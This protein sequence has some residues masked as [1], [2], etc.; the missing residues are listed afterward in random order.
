MNN[1]AALSTKKKIVII[2]IVQSPNETITVSCNGINYTSDFTCHEGDSYS[3]TVTTI[4][5][6][7][8]AGTLNIP[9]TGV[10]TEDTTITITE[11]SFIT[12]FTVNFVPEWANPD[13][14][15]NYVEDALGACCTYRNGAPESNLYADNQYGII[16][17]EHDLI[18][19][20]AWRQRK[21]T[22]N[23]YS[24]IC[25]WASPTT[26]DDFVIIDTVDVVEITSPEY[27][28]LFKNVPNSNI[29]KTGFDLFSNTYD[30]NKEPIDAAPYWKTTNEI[31]KDFLERHIGKWCT[32]H[33]KLTIKEISG[34]NTVSL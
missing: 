14:A 23:I 10:F 15:I 22:G 26:S 18:D 11:A 5:S 34:I 20:I 6:W 8:I 25:F 29:T 33:V 28:L 3:I 24:T 19:I 32:L 13:D 12:E 30:A 21:N 31:F 16:E 27:L 4:N 9:D 1:F 7:F 17:E 2:K